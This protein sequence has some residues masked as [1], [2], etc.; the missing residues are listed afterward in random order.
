MESSSSPSPLRPVL[1]AVL[2][3]FHWAI[4]AVIDGERITKL[5]W[6][7]P[8][9]YGMLRG[10]LLLI[11]RSDTGWNKWIINAGDLFGDDWVIKE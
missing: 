5:E 1:T 11:H 9:S 4:A 10:G 2:M 8:D 7:D 6:D 3:N